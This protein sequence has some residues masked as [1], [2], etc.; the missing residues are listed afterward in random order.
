MGR[1]PRLHLGSGELYIWPGFQNLDKEHDLKNL[2]YSDES[3]ESIYSV[4]LFE[5]L[6]R[7]EVNEYLAEWHRILIPDGKLVMEMPS[8]NKIC[9]MINS[10]EPNMRLTLFGIFGDPRNWAEQPLMRHEWSWTNWELEEV[11]TQAGFQVEFELPVF[12][13]E[14]RDLRVIGTKR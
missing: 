2:G 13:I 5:H 11:L 8:L 14:R 1:L 6:P 9:Q 10:G 7:L 4:H 3:V 12:H